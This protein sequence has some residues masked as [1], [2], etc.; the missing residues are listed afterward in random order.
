MFAA[1]VFT[2]HIALQTQAQPSP[3][4]GNAP[5]DHNRNQLEEIFVWKVSDELKLTVAE[6]KKLSELIRELS[7]K[8]NE[9]N[10]ESRD[11]VAQMGH[12]K[13]GQE[14]ARKN[15]LAKFRQ[16][17]DQYQKISLQEFDRIEKLLGHVRTAKYLQIKQELTTR[18]KSLIA[19]DKADKTDK[20]ENGKADRIDRSGKNKNAGNS[21]ELAPQE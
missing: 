20:A 8:K 21:P 14:K 4:P 9:L 17:I 3:S 19:I 15:L 18:V 5:P 16:N 6:E 2:L 1:V 7:Q 12:L 13:P 10:R 11:L